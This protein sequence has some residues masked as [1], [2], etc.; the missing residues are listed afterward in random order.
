MKDQVSV[1]VAR[2]PFG[3]S[4]SPDVT[5]WLIQTDRKMQQDERIAKVF[6]TRVD[7][8]PITMSRNLVVER[9]RAAKADLLL[10]IDSDMKPD[11]PG[12]HARPFWDTAFQFWFDRQEPMCIGAPYC[13]PPPHCNVFVFRWATLANPGEVEPHG[14]CVKLTQFPR[15]E[16]AQRTGIER[17]AALPTGLILIDMEV[18]SVLKPPFFYYEWEEDGL[19]CPTCGHPAGG[20][21]IKKASTEDVAFTRDVEMAAGFANYVTWDSWAGHWKR[22]CVGK[23]QLVYAD[24]VNAK[25]RD[26]VLHNAR[27]EEAVMEVQ[28]PRGLCGAVI[29]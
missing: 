7:D 21:Q 2:F 26:A 14:E 10:M 16:A 5:D 24:F 11:L 27:I 17:V 19:H 22:T 23:P 3:N 6:M 12:L 4:E 25:F 15:E 9:A 29:S 28:P 18:F 20:K 1:M 13:G 8:T